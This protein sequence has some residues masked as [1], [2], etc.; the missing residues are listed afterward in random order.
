MPN[1]TCLWPECESETLVARGLCERDYR[2]AKRAG[3]LREFQAPTRSCG[4]CR[5]EFSTGKNGKH[6]YCSVACQRAGVEIRRLEAQL[7]VR[8][9]RICGRCGEPID[10]TRKAEAGYCSIKCQKASWSS[11]NQARIND[12]ANLWRRSNPGRA[13]DSDHRRR[14]L[15]YGTRSGVIDYVQ[16]WDRDGGICWICGDSVDPS[17]TYPN[18]K[19]RSWDHVTPLSKGGTHTMDNLALSH[20]RCNTSKKDKIP[21]RLPV[22]AS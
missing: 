15:I 9:G 4:V 13:Q 11:E 16:V 6:G 1:D 18:P 2:R 19:Y 10:L 5:K 7:E 8:L 22:W 12:C 14:A 17:L 21:D 3:T 20:L